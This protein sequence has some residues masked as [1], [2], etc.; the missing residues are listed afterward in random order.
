MASGRDDDVVIAAALSP[1]HDDARAAKDGARMTLE[2]PGEH[3]SGSATCRFAYDVF[4]VHADAAADEAFVNG[5]LLPKLGLAPE[6]VLRRQ[7]LE[8]GQLITEEIERGVRSSRVTIVVLS[9]AYMDDHWAAFGEQLAAY[10]SV[11]KDVHGVLLPLLREDC[12]LTMHV[13][14]LVKLDFRD[15]SRALW[16][17]E[18]DRLHAYLDRPAVA[19]ADLPCPYPGMRPFTE[20]DVGRF[21]GAGPSGGVLAG[22]SSRRTSSAS[23][24]AG[25]VS[26][27]ASSTSASVCRNVR[28]RRTTSAQPPPEGSTLWP[29]CP[30][31]GWSRRM[32][33]GDCG[34]MPQAARSWQTSRFRCASCRCGSMGLAL[35]PSRSA[36]CIPARIELALQR[37]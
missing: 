16:E 20:D 33:N 32:R 26:P 8:L 17:A 25:S 27:R 19:G 12:K 28:P 4:V 30:M 23:R 9:A 21:F 3:V 14:A 29:S 31:A 22:P 10:A 15:P 1:E 36:R 2:A 18:I 34:S 24:A 6:R 37:S 13:Q 5:Y 11:A 35:S 7:P